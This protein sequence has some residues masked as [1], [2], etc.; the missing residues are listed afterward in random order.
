MNETMAALECAPLGANVRRFPLVWSEA[1]IAELKRAADQE[2]QEDDAIASEV[3]RVLL[4]CSVGDFVNAERSSIDLLK[5]YT[6]RCLQSNPVFV[7][8]LSAVFVVQRF[9]LVTSM[10]RDRY[11]FSSGLEI[12]AEET[13]HAAACVR[14]DILPSGIHRFVF[15]RS[16]Y[17]DDLTTHRMHQFQREFPLLAFY[18][19]QPEQERGSVLLNQFDLGL[20][21]GLAYCDARPDYFLVPDCIFVPTRGYENARKALDRNRV[22]WQEREG[23]AF[24]RGSTT[25]PKAGPNDWR[26]LSRIRLCE[27]ARQPRAN[28]LVDAGITQVVQLRDPV[29]GEQIS[30]AG[31]MKDFVPWQS[32]GRYKYLIVIDGNSSP[33]SN[34]IQGFLTGSTILK[35][36]SPRGLMQWYYGELVPWRN[37]IPIAPDMSDLVD[38]VRWLLKHDKYAEDVGHRG[39]ELADHLTYERELR[40]SVPVI[41]A[42]FKYFRGDAD[43][44]TP[45]GWVE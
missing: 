25:G 34:L 38:K 44:N 45:F 4:R 37:Y 7:S 31:L 6:G 11:G 8:L 27:I 23:V 41:S 14:W 16:V 3:A 15:D 2:K 43:N 36:E 19:S 30:Q 33:W 35:V 20:L 13:G 22:S 21:P 24:W 32:W 12:T 40:R 42:A 10:L 1:K 39:K 5:R 9:D 18:A 26:S 29:V 28:G 17:A